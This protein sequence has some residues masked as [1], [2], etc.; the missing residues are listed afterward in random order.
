MLPF[1]HRYLALR[2]LMPVALCAPVLLAISSSTAAEQRVLQIGDR[3]LSI[4][5]DGKSG[6][7]PTVVL[8]AGGGRTAKDWSKVQ[9]IVAESTRV[10]S[11]DR[12]GL[13][14]SGSVSKQQTVGE[15]VD[16]LHALLKAAGEKPPYVLVAH[17]IAGLY[18]RSFEA[19][20][21]GETAALVFVDSSHEEQALRQ[22]ELD[23][24]LPWLIGPTAK[25]G[26]LVQPDDRLRWRTELPV[27]VLMHG[28]AIPLPAPTSASQSEAWES[29]W[30]ELQEDL[31]KRSPLGQFRV[32]AD[33]GH[34]IQI[35]QPE[36]VIQAI[37]D[38]SM[39]TQKVR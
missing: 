18:A 25:Q 8:M 27:I 22:H 5:C 28:K 34:F 23:P 14:E 33:S 29:I 16:D 32:A 30:R 11:Y 7:T 31:A 1:H 6:P 2:R 38:V 26:F 21:S 37:R 39:M 10:C 15:I 35:D 12:A 9:P 19:R 20:F 36:L 3:S 17:S 24:K 13:G 4:E